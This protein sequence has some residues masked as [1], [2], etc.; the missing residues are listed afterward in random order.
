MKAD[1]FAPFKE[2]MVK[3]V[4]SFK[5]GSAFELISIQNK[6]KEKSMI[7]FVLSFNIKRNLMGELIKRKDRFYTR[8]S[9][10]VKGTDHWNTYA[11]VAQTNTTRLMLILH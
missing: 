2:A 8:Y 10:Q 5:K 1:D 3:E 9:K 7:P 6:P 4:D 11:P